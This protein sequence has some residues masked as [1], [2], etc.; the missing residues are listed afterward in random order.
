MFIC[1]VVCVG[2]III[3]L[4][5]RRVCLCCGVLII[6][7]SSMM[8]ALCVFYCCYDYEYDVFISWC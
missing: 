3:M 8:C 6:V 7:V 4:S 5:S 1:I 2:V